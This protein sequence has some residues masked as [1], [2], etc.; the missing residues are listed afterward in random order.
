MEDSINN[1]LIKYDEVAKLI[2]DQKLDELSDQMQDLPVDAEDF[3]YE[4]YIQRIVMEETRIVTKSMETEPNDEL[5]GLSMGK[6]FEACDFSVLVEILEFCSLNLDNGVPES[7]IDAIANKD[8]KDTTYEYAKNTIVSSAWTED[9]LGDADS[10][11]EIEF[12]K[13][14]ACL[15]VLRKCNNSSLVGTVLE[16]FMSYAQTRDFVAESIA[17]YIEAFPE[18]SVPLMIA[19]LE[20]HE[21]EGL[22]GPCEDLIIMLSHIGKEHPADEIFF[23]IKEAFRA[24]KNKIYAVIC[25]AE[26]GDGRAIPMLK[27]Y[28]NRNQKTIDRDL[29]YEIMT[30][31]RDLGGDI[32][33]IQDPFGDFEK[34]NEGKL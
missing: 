11:F 28:I 5:N 33:D 31:I 19:T 2:L 29:F 4:E 8:D 23:A 6:Y 24:M 14:K 9:E 21:S 15:A 18:V 30:A 1:V 32:S 20:K 26:L 34:K 12:A 27:G 10:I 17:D 3:S 13:I 7:V 16:R 22:T 25:L